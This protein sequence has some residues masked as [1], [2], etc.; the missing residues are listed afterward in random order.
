MIEVN[1]QLTLKDYISFNYSHFFRSRMA[2]FYMGFLAFMTILMIFNFVAM[3]ADVEY[4]EPDSPG[5]YF[6]WLLPLIF[7][8]SIVSVYFQARK[9]FLNSKQLQAPILFTFTADNVSIKGTDFDTFNTWD[10]YQK[11]EETKKLFVLFQNNVSVNLIPKADF[12]S[13][14]EIKALRTLFASKPNLKKKL[15]KG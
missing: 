1:T 14:N 7:I 15:L 8:F 10:L 6:G 2:K 13:S 3:P 4:E 5:N 9:N 11:V 12:A